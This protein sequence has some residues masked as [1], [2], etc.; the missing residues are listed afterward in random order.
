MDKAVFNWSGGK[1]SALALWEILQEGKYEVISL[2]TTVNKETKL[3]SMH[4]ISES[5]LCKQAESIGLPIHIL[6]LTPKGDMI[7]Y[8]KAMIKS[9]EHFKKQGVTDYIFGDIHL[10]DVRR[11]REEQLNPLGITVVEP[12]WEK[13][14]KI[15]MNKFLKSGLKTIITTTTTDLL[16]KDFVGRIIDDSF[17]ADLP[18]NIDICGEN[19]EYHSF[20]YGGGMFKY[21]I[22]FKLGSV[23]TKSY[24]IKPQDGKEEE[25]TYYFAEILE[26]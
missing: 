11:Y 12:I 8:E 26:D 14:T 2:L 18:P 5:L 13:D 15:V 25:F 22:S 23:Q 7:D 17:I 20:C 16:G 19:G 24:S 6:D 10:E 21:P 9:V 3:S 4:N 1:D